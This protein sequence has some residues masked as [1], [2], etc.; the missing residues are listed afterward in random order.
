MSHS[1]NLKYRIPLVYRTEYLTLFFLGGVGVG[2][3]LKGGA[4][5]KY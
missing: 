5:S 3:Y 1:F 2:T 4:Y